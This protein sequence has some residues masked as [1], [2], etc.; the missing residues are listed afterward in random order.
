MSRMQDVRRVAKTATAG[1]HNSCDGD[2][3]SAKNEACQGRSL[4]I[5]GT[6]GTLD[7]FSCLA[8]LGALPAEAD[9]RRNAT[10]HGG[11]H[12]QDGQLPRPKVHTMVQAE[13]RKV[14]RHMYVA[15]VLDNDDGSDGEEKARKTAEHKRNC[16]WT[17]S[18]VAP[19][20]EVNRGPR[21]RHY[22]SNHNSEG[23]LILRRKCG[24]KHLG[25]LRR[26]PNLQD[27]RRRGDLCRQHGCRRLLLWLHMDCWCWSL[28]PIRS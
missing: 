16:L 20:N 12:E 27:L 6:P 9:H 3:E 5:L 15:V 25:W 7:I 22:R 2:E 26:R 28:R 11:K 18:C 17:A 14:L 10:E 1:G 24:G 4:Q 8:T 21:Q 19:I 13:A 23:V